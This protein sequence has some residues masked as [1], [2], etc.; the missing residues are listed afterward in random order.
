MLRYAKAYR[1]VREIRRSG[2]RK[3]SEDSV[4]HGVFSEFSV[5]LSK[6]CW[7][8]QME[9]TTG[10]REL[11]RKL[12]GDR[13]DLK[14]SAAAMPSYF[15][16]TRSTELVM[17]QDWQQYFSTKGDVLFVCLS[18]HWGIQT[19]FFFRGAVTSSLGEVQTWTVS[20]LQ[21]QKITKTIEKGIMEWGDGGLST[22]NMRIN[23]C[24]LWRKTPETRVESNLVVSSWSLDLGLS[25]NRVY[26]QL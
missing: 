3:F 20:F 2:S 17:G 15:F 10:S 23:P 4:F 6:A 1:F 21:A 19:V 24:H 26:Y 5:K 7:T 16:L 11:S 18:M 12:L 14:L 8:L 9:W 22:F 13:P 25:E